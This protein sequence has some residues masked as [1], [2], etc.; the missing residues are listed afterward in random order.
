MTFG[1]LLAAIILAIAIF[2]IGGQLM[3]FGGST[4]L[5]SLFG[6]AEEGFQL[7]EQHGD[8]NQGF[9]QAWALGNN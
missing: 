5:A 8:I 6:A 2:T 9:D 4:E 1:K 3:D 7:I